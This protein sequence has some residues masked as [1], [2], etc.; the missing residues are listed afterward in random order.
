MQANEGNFIGLFLILI[1]FAVQLLFVPRSGEKQGQFCM[2]NM[3]T[4]PGEK[5][6]ASSTSMKQKRFPMT[7]LVTATF[8]SGLMMFVISS[9]FAQAN[10]PCSSSHTINSTVVVDTS[11][12]NAQAASIDHPLVICNRNNQQIGWLTWLFKRSDSVDFHYLDLLELL[13]R[14]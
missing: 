2:T 3:P 4:T 9:V 10:A 12:S 14:K 7:M 13:Y 8:F 1:G 5:Q 6:R 11:H